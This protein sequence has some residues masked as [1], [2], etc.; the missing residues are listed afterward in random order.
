MRVSSYGNLFYKI[1]LKALRTVGLI[2]FCDPEHLHALIM[3]DD[4][5]TGI[6]IHS[7]Q[8]SGQIVSQAGVGGQNGNRAHAMSRL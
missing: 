7:E 6:D 2:I 1:I 3:G 5:Q 8:G 4:F